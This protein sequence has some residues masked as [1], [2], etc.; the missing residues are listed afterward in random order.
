MRRFAGPLIGGEPLPEVPEDNKGPGWEGL[1]KSVE[2]IRDNPD[3]PADV[4]GRLNNV[5]HRIERL[6]K[7]APSYDE[8]E[9]KIKKMIKEARRNCYCLSTQHFF[10]GSP[11]KEKKISERGADELKVYDD[12]LFLIEKME[13]KE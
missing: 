8:R 2:D 1:K 10:C 12:L 7:G 3:G 5:L 4:Y 6:E 9:S 13:E 11:S